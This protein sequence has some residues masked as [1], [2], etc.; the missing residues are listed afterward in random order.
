MVASASVVLGGCEENASSFS[1]FIWSHTHIFSMCSYYCSSNSAGEARHHGGLG[2][3][4][5]IFRCAHSLVLPP[6][7]PNKLLTAAGA[8]VALGR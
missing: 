8:Q 4:K 2:E 6:A 1:L 7:E 5:L 3:G